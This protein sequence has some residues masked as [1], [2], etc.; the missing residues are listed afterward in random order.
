MQRSDVVA[1]LHK[2]GLPDLA[3]LAEQRLDDQV[4]L[5]EVQDLMAPYGVTTEVLMDRMGASP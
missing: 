5:K 1:T 3:A 4:D 2:V